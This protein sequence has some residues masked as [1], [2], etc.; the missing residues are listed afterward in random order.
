MYG[1]HWCS[2]KETLAWYSTAY[3]FLLAS[4]VLIAH[5][6]QHS[7]TPRPS[8]QQASRVLQAFGQQLAGSWLLLSAGRQCCW[9]KDKPKEAANANRKKI[10]VHYS[11]SSFLYKLLA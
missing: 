8:H 2:V 10:A 1:K 7:R 3:L 6:H 5:F 4:A 11:V 9:L